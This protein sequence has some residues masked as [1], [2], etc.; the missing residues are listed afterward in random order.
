MASKRA[1]S[2]LSRDRGLTQYW[3]GG[4]NWSL[5]SAVLTI[6]WES[7]KLP[8]YHASARFEFTV[9][10]VRTRELDALSELL[11]D[12]QLAESNRVHATARSCRSN[13]DGLPAAVVAERAV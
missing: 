4:G 7:R 12:S 11:P 6:V 10:N 8:N 5:D 9:C 13:P 3:R 2:S 1:F